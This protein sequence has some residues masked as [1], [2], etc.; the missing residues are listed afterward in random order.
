VDQLHGI[1]L[2]HQDPDVIGNAPALLARNPRARLMVTEDVWRLA[3]HMLPRPHEIH[4]VNASHS[5]TALI[6]SHH[7]WQLVP[8]P[9]CHFRGAMAFY[10]PELRVLFSGD[11][12][13]GLNRLGRVQLDAEESDWAGIAQ[14]HQIYMPGRNALRYAIRQIRALD[15]PVEV[16]APQHGFVIRGELVPLFLERLYDLPVGHDLL[17]LELDETYLDGY[18]DLLLQ[19]IRR[20]A[21][22]LGHEE[23]LRRLQTPAGNGRPSVPDGRPSVP[24]GRPSVPDGRPS[25]PDGR[26]PVPDGRPSVP[27]GLS[28]LLRIEGDD[29][30]LEREG[31][32]AIVKVLTRLCQG[33]TAAIANRLRSE[34]LGVCTERGLPIP[35]IGAGLDEGDDDLDPPPDRDPPPKEPPRFVFPNLDQRIGGD[36]TWATTLDTLRPPPEDGRRNFQW[37]REAAIRPVVFDAPQ[38]IDESVV[39]LHLHHRVVQRL[40][41]RFLAQGFVHH[42]LSRACLGQSED[43]VHRVAL[44]GRLSMYGAGAAR[45]HE[46]ILTVTARWV[47]PAKRDGGLKP[48]AREAEARTLDMLESSLKPGASIDVPEA[49][50]KRLLE[51]IG[52]DIEELLP[53]LHER[54]EAAR[55]SA[56]E[57]LAQRGQTEA[58]EIRRILEDQKKRIL[59]ELGKSV[60]RQL[61][62]FDTDDEK[63]Q[64]ES[65]RRYWQRW[66]ENVEGDLNREPARILDFYRTSSYRIEPVGIAYLYPART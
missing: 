16:I 36:P 39:Q 25:V 8:T 31:Y 6:G 54:G 35:P 27:D 26:P 48:Y 47:E 7:G 38:G 3:R 30:H 56:E 12:F 44:L 14:F 18:R 4:F 33:Q 63:R 10:D 41:S 2:N 19:L 58:A 40:L 24:D 53:H 45:L 62:L 11:L 46:E 50:A 55:Q 9:F 17:P 5:P 29:V 64:Y 1:S 57:A 21:E 66:I 52:R 32:A 43:N 42:D 51:S 34:V 23:V 28:H 22:I 49:T 20:A 65:N 59:A 60:D 37:R 15:P 13:G 61:L